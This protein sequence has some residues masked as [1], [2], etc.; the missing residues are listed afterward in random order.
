MT[1][2]VLPMD[3]R[4]NIVAAIRL[5]RIFVMGVL[6]FFF[7]LS[8]AL[9]A[10]GPIV[11]PVGTVV[12]RPIEA[13]E[14]LDCGTQGLVIIELDQVYSRCSTL[15]PTERKRLHF[16][17]GY[18]VMMIDKFSFCASL[19]EAATGPIAEVERFDKGRISFQ[20]PVRQLRLPLWVPLAG[21]SVYAVLQLIGW[22][23]RRI[24][25]QWAISGRCIKCGYSLYG[26][27]VN[28]CPEC[29]TKF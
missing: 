3:V 16:E 4:L 18:I 27:T 29:G 12:P 26:L 8:C 1:S 23:R 21:L 5:G 17:V 10:I 13:V 25:A 22:H 9:L 2:S 24:V 15:N 11:V 20:Y 6:L 14:V 28:R 19:I 7:L